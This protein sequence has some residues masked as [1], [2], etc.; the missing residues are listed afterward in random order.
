MDRQSQQGRR[1]RR[2]WPVDRARHQVRGELPAARSTRQPRHGGGGTVADFGPHTAQGASRPDDRQAGGQRESQGHH[3]SEDRAA[4][5]EASPGPRLLCARRDAR[6]RGPAAQACDVLLGCRRSPDRRRERAVAPHGGP[7][8]ARRHQRH[9]RTRQRRSGHPSSVRAA[10]A[11]GARWPRH[12]PRVKPTWR[13]STET[14]RLRLAAHRCTAI[15]GDDARQ[16]GLTR[17]TVAARRSNVPLREYSGRPI[18]RRRSSHRRSAPGCAP[19]R[20]AR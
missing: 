10:A 19:S 4:R 3:R 1:G 7:A 17:R 18:E 2:T 11:G 5:A 16:Y 13:A 15:D 6:T 20:W 14:E 8:H 12:A 9:G